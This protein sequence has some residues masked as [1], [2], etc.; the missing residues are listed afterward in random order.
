MLLFI[1]VIGLLGKYMY[2]YAMKSKLFLKI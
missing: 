2:C 1:V